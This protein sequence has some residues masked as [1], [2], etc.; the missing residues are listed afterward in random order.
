MV[1]KSVQSSGVSD[2]MNLLVINEGME[3]HM[4][5]MREDKIEHA[6]HSDIPLH[7]QVD[8]SEPGELFTQVVQKESELQS[9]KRNYEQAS[10]TM[11]KQKKEIVELQD[12]IAK[13]E[14]YLQEKQRL[15][16][17]R[18]GNIHQL[19]QQLQEM[20]RT[21][22][23]LEDEVKKFGSIQKENES[24]H[25]EVEQL[26][27]RLKNE[28][29]NEQELKKELAKAKK[30]FDKLHS[31]LENRNRQ[32]DILKRDLQDRNKRVTNLQEKIRKLK[33]ESNNLSRGKLQT[34]E[35]LK[36]LQDQLSEL[37]KTSA[38]QIQSLK[39]QLAHTDSESTRISRYDNSLIGSLSKRIEELR[40]EGDNNQSEIQRLQEQLKQSSEKVN[41]WREK[42]REFKQ[43]KREYE[44]QLRDSN[45]IQTLYLEQIA[46]LEQKLFDSTLEINELRDELDNRQDIVPI[47]VVEQPVEEVQQ[48]PKPIALAPEGITLPIPEIKDNQK[49][50]LQKR[51][52]GSGLL[53]FRQLFDWRQMW[54]TLKFNWL[55]IVLIAVMGPMGA[56]MS[57][58]WL[59]NSSKRAWTNAFYWFIPF[60][61]M[62]V[63]LDMALT[64]RSMNKEKMPSENDFMLPLISW[65]YFIPNLLP[66]SFT[67]LSNKQK[68]Q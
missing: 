29:N 34:E 59:Y 6:K 9:V 49:Q 36:E 64:A 40:T 66:A 15:V 8:K 47:L 67:Q 65:L 4:K 42:K 17:E 25:H 63:W 31:E 23:S 7:I 44:Q 30:K 35:Q 2:P 55:F 37:K 48:R 68:Q 16:V 20:S 60:V 53:D 38:K 3:Q 33:E 14:T 10:T 24:A 58:K 22:Q 43:T 57:S 18:D 50:A 52:F 1:E 28:T 11:D 12:K 62:Y 46:Q 45:S 26:Q 27:Q 19:Q 32:M 54:D 13:F 39:G 51:S 61:N 21:K 56:F 41:K 5:K